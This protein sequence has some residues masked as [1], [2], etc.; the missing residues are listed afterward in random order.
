MADRIEVSLAT[1]RSEPVWGI[2]RMLA[3]EAPC[4]ECGD[5][6][7][8]KGMGLLGHLR[9]KHGLSRWDYY[10]L[11]PEA[12]Q[13][14]RYHFTCVECRASEIRVDPELPEG[15]RTLDLRVDE[16]PESDARYAAIFCSD[17]C[18]PV[19]EGDL[20]RVHPLAVPERTSVAKVG[21]T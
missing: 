14:L 13:A 17:E 4:L 2:E 19:K 21:V 18:C 7:L 9:Q 15:W 12:E 1:L 3:R 11:H 10:D 20:P 6:R 5:D 16:H 8:F